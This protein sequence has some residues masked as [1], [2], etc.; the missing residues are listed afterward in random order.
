MKKSIFWTVLFFMS[1]VGVAQTNESWY[2]V[3][4]GKVGNMS[5]TLHLHKAGK[6]YCGYI[7]FAQNQW[8]MP[9]YYNE[10]AVK[11]DS[12][13]ISAIGGPV[14]F[15]FS[16]VFTNDSYSGKST[17]QKENNPSKSASFQLEVSNDKIFTPLKFYSAAGDAKLLPQI[18][19]ESEASYLI[20]SIWPP[21]NDATGIAIK[22]YV[23]QSLGIKAPVADPLKWMTDEKNK[24]LAT[25]KKENSKMSPKEAS[26]MGLSLSVEEEE[27]VMIM[28]ESEQTITV[29]HY[30]YGFT[31]GAHGNFG[32]TLATIQK[33]TGKK[34]ALTDIINPAGIKALPAI[35]D[36]VARVQFEIKNNKP[37]DQNNFLVNKISP[38]ENFYVTTTGIG[39]L[40]PP[41]EIKS[42]ADGEVNLLVPFTAL[43]P[44]LQPVFKH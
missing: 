7:W 32:T 35:L 4:T 9:I 1:F 33:P 8:P 20:A 26:E 15:V 43:G 34:L 27:R 29:A 38:S 40:Y 37:L 10:P 16:G 12:L 41:Y 14:S 42:F 21:G 23:Q 44:Y 18:K 2:K 17:L 3:L 6:N 36:K 24:F 13:E 22:K 28:Y 30:S 19:N 5:A 11:N 25:W 39:F 31:G